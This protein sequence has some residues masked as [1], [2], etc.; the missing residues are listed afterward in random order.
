MYRQ[1]DEYDDVMNSRVTMNASKKRLPCLNPVSYLFSQIK[2][3]LE[4]SQ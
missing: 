1:N 3:R 2:F 4:T